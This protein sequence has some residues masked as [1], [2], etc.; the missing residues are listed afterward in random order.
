LKLYLDT[1]L[2]V[3]ALTR[4]TKTR[5][6]QTW[7]GEQEDGSLVISD[8]VLTEFS[9]A[10]AIKLRTG[11]IKENDRSEALAGFTRLCSESLLMLPVSRRH[12]HT[13]ARFAD[14][15]ILGLRGGDALHLAIC[16]DHG[17]KMCTLDRRLNAA[18]LSLGVNTNLL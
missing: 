14:E 10:I 12:F 3:A 8:W 2:V 17:V 6:I 7:F 13:A 16:V 4:E 11:Q 9:A 18:G 5:R 1:S 15:Y